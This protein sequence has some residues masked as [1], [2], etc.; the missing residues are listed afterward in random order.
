MH[1]KVRRCQ[2]QA[3]PRIPH[4]RAMSNTSMGLLKASECK[5]KRVRHGY[6]G[7]HLVRRG[8][9]CQGRGCPVLGMLLAR[10]CPVL[11]MLLVRGCQG[12]GT[13]GCWDCC[14]ELVTRVNL[15]HGQRYLL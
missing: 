3:V 12:L 7:T 9:R 2:I 8:C 5:A 1:A 10:G 6:G 4:Q 13:L 14:R 15:H 11:G